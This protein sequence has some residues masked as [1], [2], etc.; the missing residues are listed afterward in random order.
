MNTGEL[1][2]L[3]ALVQLIAELDRIHPN[4]SFDP[5][6]LRDE[7]GMPD[8]VTTKNGYHREFGS[9]ARLAVLA[10]VNAWSNEVPSLSIR[11]ELR[12]LATLLRQKVADLH[13]EGLFGEDSA[14]NLNLLNQ[15]VQQVL[16]NTDTD[17]THSFPAWT[18]GFEFEEPLS[19]GPVT[20]MSRDQ[21]LDTVDFS[22]NAKNSFFGG[23]SEN[24]KWKQSL[25]DA[26]AK[27]KGVI[28]EGE[29]P[30]PPLASFL[31]GPLS[32]CRSLLRVSM[33]GYERSLSIKA[34]RHISKTALDGLSLIMGG[35]SVFHQQTLIDERMPPVERH[36][37]IESQG[38]LW[39]PGFGLNQQIL[40]LSGRDAKALLHDEKRRP[41]REALAH[42]LEGLSPTP[43]RPH[44]HP[45]L[46]MRWAIALDWLAEGEREI[47]EA[48]ALTKIGT[49]LDVLTEGGKFGGILDML[50]H[51]TGWKEDTEFRVGANHRDLRSL[52]KEL[53]DHGRSKILHGNVVDRLRSYAEIRKVGAMLARI[54]LI[55]CA[56]RLK[57][58]TDADTSK[59]FR[60]MPEPAQD[61]EGIK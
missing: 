20:F 35:G 4:G 53:Y 18:L 31:Y 51:L 54:A 27:P 33:S 13:A 36:T 7:R 59:A 16:A 55:E 47:N 60:N 22:E 24:E 38:Y 42:I 21:W 56:L 57:H 26:L 10:L 46:A 45:Q 9:A 19:V 41:M 6:S 44:P 52:V 23:S 25:R 17:F 43:S 2:R 14:A 15:E 28:L 8:F 34:A 1:N 37:L 5:S 12:A 39:M 49:S 3:E 61:P 58:Y 40:T 30:L 32:S 50:T 11:V 29:E 48:I